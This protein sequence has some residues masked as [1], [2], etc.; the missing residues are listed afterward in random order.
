[1]D[2]TVH[3]PYGLKDRYEAYHRV[4]ITDEAIVAAAELS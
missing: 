4:R 2:E 1:M 3:V